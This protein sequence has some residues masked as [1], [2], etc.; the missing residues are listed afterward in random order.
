MFETT[1]KDPAQVRIDNERK[2]QR[3]KQ[4]A[5]FAKQEAELLEEKRKREALV[6]TLDERWQARVR[7]V[8]K[9]AAKFKRAGEPD[10]AGK[11]QAS[12]DEM[13]DAL[14]E[15]RNL[16]KELTAKRPNPLADATAKAGAQLRKLL[17]SCFES[18]EEAGLWAGNNLPLTEARAAQVKTTDDHLRLGRKRG[19]AQNR[20][21]QAYSEG[22]RLGTGSVD[23][24]ALRDVE[25]LGTEY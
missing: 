25:I 1:E 20:F 17:P 10:K 3:D 4:N 23:S 6:P 18:A 15:Y 12:A 13:S 24:S 11:I 19:L 14:T 22:V 21:E 9:L 16:T 5:I 8:T 7:G 2:R